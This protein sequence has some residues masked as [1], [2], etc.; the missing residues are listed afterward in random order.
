MC[1]LLLDPGVAQNF[2]SGRIP[3]TKHIM[4]KKTG[5]AEMVSYAEFKYAFIVFLSKKFSL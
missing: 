2:L 1:K 4:L 5:M 3:G